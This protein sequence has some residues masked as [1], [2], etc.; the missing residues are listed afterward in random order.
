MGEILRR[1]LSGRRGNAGCCRYHILLLRIGESGYFLKME[2]PCL[3]RIFGSFYKDS[4]LSLGNT[5]YGFRF[6][7]FHPPLVLVKFSPTRCQAFP[8]ATRRGN[9]LYDAAVAPRRFPSFSDVNWRRDL[10]GIR[11]REE[12]E[13]VGKKERSSFLFELSKVVLSLCLI[14]DISRS[15]AW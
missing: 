9:S 2:H 15:E 14:R 12:E 4:Y 13:R 8:D 3:L 10:S 6:W 1:F 7:W 5:I 11:H